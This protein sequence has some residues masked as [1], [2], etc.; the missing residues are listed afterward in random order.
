MVN[1]IF[2]F[3]RIIKAKSNNVIELI[4]III[5][6][7][8]IFFFGI[9]D[10]EEYQFG[11]F[12]S[13]IYWQNLSSLF[14]VFYDFYGPGVKMPIGHGPLLHPLNFLFFN[15][16]IYYV[17]F[18]SFHLFL[19]IYFTKRLFKI[20]QIKYDNYILVICL[21]FCLPNILYGISEDWISELWGYSIFP[22]MF[23]YL[24]KIIKT[25]KILSYLKFALFFFLWIV[26]GHIGVISIYLI[27]FLLYILFSIE[28]FQ[29][30]KKIF[31]FSLILSFIFVALMLSDYVYYMLREMSLF[32]ISSVKSFQP[33]YSKRAFVEI[34]YPFQHFLSWWPINRLPGNPILIF[35]S[36]GITFYTAYKSIEIFGKNFQ[37]SKKKLFFH[38][39]IIFFKKKLHL[40]NNFKFSFLFGIFI[41]FS[42]TN[43]L[44][45]THIVSGMWYSRDIFL[46]ISL[47]LYFLNYENFGKVIKR[48][49]NFLVIIYTFLFFII[50]VY[51]LYLKNENNFI[52]NKYQETD[53][54][55][56]LKKLDVKENDYKRIYLS[57]ELF[58]DIWMGY[59]N[60]GIFAV[61][62]LIKFNLSPFTGFFKNTS[63][64]GFGN[65]EKIMHG[66]IA[67]NF[68][69]INNE[70]FLDIYKINYLLIKQE[71]LKKLKNH[72]FKVEEIINTENGKLYLFER[73][74]L[75]YSIKKK[76][77]N[78]LKSNLKI[79]NKIKIECLLDNRYLFEKSDHKLKRY[80]NGK[81]FISEIK[82]NEL[83]F[84]PFIYD[85]NWSTADGNFFGI[86]N[87]SMFFQKENR[88]TN[89]VIKIEYS[90][91]LRFFLKILSLSSFLILTLTII[92]INNKIKKF[93]FFKN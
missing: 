85:P 89:K 32:D 84:L 16:K 26:N 46:F 43:I 2:D 69:H 66:L 53:L 5:F 67:S 14:T 7:S 79:C 52:L 22:L 40:D 82:D 29:H 72:N 71:E 23:Y 56:K 15:L 38:D 60:D 17:S 74:V 87:F 51:S 50:N 62:D 88:S 27:F 4:F 54:K 83:I 39:F 45:H 59:E 12:S 10:I 73:K 80:G 65:E 93:K 13:Q 35:F 75:N 37:K 68:S 63:M 81:F 28:N 18:V 34:F 25:Q 58:P 9:N 64:H 57:P 49:L 41:I 86:N 19:Q 1:N 31:N 6:T 78:I 92:Y 24:V 11:L 47:F 42:I 20:F 44:E 3:T 55:R 21:V 33:S 61:T 30:L 70:F 76:N 77:Y 36:V 8:V 90:D 48:L 91:K